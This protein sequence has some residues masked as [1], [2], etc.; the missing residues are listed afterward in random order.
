MQIIL[1][2]HNCEGQAQAIFD[3]L[4]Y[5]GEWLD[6]VPMEL[7]WFDDVGLLSTADDKVVWEFCQEMGYLLLTGN[8]STKADAKSL[9]YQIRDLATPNCLSVL[10]IGNLKRVLPD[11]N[12]R[13]RCAI[14]LATIVDELHL[15]RGVIRLFLP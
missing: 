11:I 12:Y 9:E 10:T 5:Q 4:R 8:R 1:S 15:C 2:D 3:D 7:K 14:R 6:L 13:R